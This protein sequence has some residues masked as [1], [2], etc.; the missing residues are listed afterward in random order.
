MRDLF[1]IFTVMALLGVGG[2]LTSLWLGHDQPQTTPHEVTQ[3]VTPEQAPT[4]ANPDGGAPTANP[5]SEAESALEAG[6]L[7]PSEPT[8]PTEPLPSLDGSDEAISAAIV[9]AAGA[10]GV[11]QFVELDHVIRKLVVTLDNLPGG[12]VAVRNR[13]VKPIAGAFATTADAEAPLLDVA[14]YVRYHAFVEFVTRIEPARAVQIYRRFYPLFQQAYV[15]L[16]YPG[17]RFNPRLIAVLDHLLATD[18]AAMPIKLEQPKVL[19]VYADP[20][21][22]SLSPGR[23]VLL[24]IGPDNARALK[25]WLRKIRM[26]LMDS[27]ASGPAH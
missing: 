15:E 22:E 1:K 25:A 14:N 9:V 4:V 10:T 19:Y 6:P 24:R 2:Y 7:E 3:A 8:P 12:K 18:D 11:A 27:S 5:A 13:L 20:A 21:L 16:G 17:K 23:K 26:A